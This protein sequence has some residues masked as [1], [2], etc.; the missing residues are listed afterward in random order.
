MKQIVNKLSWVIGGAQGSGVDTAANIFAKACV[1]GGLHIYGK[2]EYHSNIKG[3]HSY[4][5]ISVS[6]KPIRSC[7]DEIDFL[8]AFDAETIFTHALYVVNGGVIL[9]DS[10]LAKISIEEVPTM[11]DFAMKELKIKM[12]SK[13]KGETIKDLLDLVKENGVN[14]YPVEFKNLLRELAE[15][16]NEPSMSKLIRMINVMVMA[17]SFALLC[18]DESIITNAIRYAFK[19]KPKIIDMNVEAASYSYNYTKAKFGN[20]FKYRLMTREVDNSL[21]LIQG[22]QAA[23][24]G[25][26]V[27]G[28]RFQTYYPITPASDESE[29]L[30]T[31]EV[32]NLVDSSDKVAFIVIQSEDEIAAITMATGGA[33]SGARSA[34]C[35]SGPGFSL[36][37]EGLGWAGINEIPIVI[38]LY[39]RAGPATG[40]PTR[41]EQG[42]LL[43]AIHAG[44]GEFPKIVFASGDVEETFYDTMKVF[45]YAEKYQMP[46]IH[47]FDKALANTVLTIK[48]FD[49]KKVKIDRGLFANKVSNGYERF[50][51]TKNGISPRVKL[52]TENGIFWNTGDEHEPNGHITEHPTIRMKMMDKRMG[53]MDLVLKELPDEDKIQMYDEK[54]DMTIISWG[55]TKGVILDV[56]DLLTKDGN[57]INYVQVKLL[58]PFPSKL[59]ESLLSKTHLLIDIEMNYSGQLA[60]LISENIKREP[61]YLIVKYNG[62][63]MSLNEVY[64]VLKKIIDGKANKIEVLTSGT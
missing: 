11:E 7:V 22:Y 27:A 42:D 28:C 40:L 24:L 46:V 50:E 3:K 61:D 47:M 32:L 34:T 31:N 37:V 20:N 12:S 9:Y 59:L 4:F 21:I 18:Y 52:G 17:S 44:H 30:E 14:I 51:F 45:N 2:R 26:I 5:N 55:S 60:R 48:R 57:K 62:R 15:K 8:V 58:N 29:Y 36:M 23:G 54:S 43:F 41:H 56:L 16:N 38:T 13:N 39:Q 49:T 10:S 33:L 19:T 1:L 25:K 64:N 53:K 35:T 63:P 6:E